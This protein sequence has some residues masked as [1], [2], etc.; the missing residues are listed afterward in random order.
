MAA[1]PRS[2][3]DIA[4][5]LSLAIWASDAKAQWICKLRHS[6]GELSHDKNGFQVTYNHV[7]LNLKKKKEEKKSCWRMKFGVKQGSLWISSS[8]NRVVTSTH[9]SDD[10]C[11]DLRTAL[12]ARPHGQHSFQPSPVSIQRSQ[13]GNKIHMPFWPHLQIEIISKREY[14]H[15]EGRQLTGTPLL[16]YG[17]D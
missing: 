17:T 14:S 11:L 8:S 10:K 16:R 5:L 15:S 3:S 6:H 13:A 7:L 9:G 1:L 4:A 2:Q 12:N